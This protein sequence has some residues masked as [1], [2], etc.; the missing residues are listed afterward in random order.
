MSTSKRVSGAKRPYSNALR[1]NQSKS[2]RELILQS[3]N[4]II[5]ENRILTFTVEELADRAG[6]S[7]RS[8]YRYFPTKD[9]LLRALANYNKDLVEQLKVESLASYSNDITS[10]VETTFANFDKYPVLVRAINVSDMISHIEISGREEADN[11]VKQFLM[12][13]APNLDSQEGKHVFAVVRFLISSLAW[14]TLRERFGLESQEA[15]KAVTW[16]IEAL[17]RDIKKKNAQ[18]GRNLK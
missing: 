9:A 3:L 12:S 1:Q 4:E 16:A 17:I 11:L 13:L 2:T 10:I 14:Q 18:A 15:R 8:V 5:A 6:V 7:H